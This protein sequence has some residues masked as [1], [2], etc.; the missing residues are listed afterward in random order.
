MSGGAVSCGGAEG[1][2]IGVV[3]GGNELVDGALAA[4]AA[5]GVGATIAIGFDGGSERGVVVLFV[6]ELELGNVECCEDSTGGVAGT[7]GGSEVA[8][9]GFGGSVFTMVEGAESWKNDGAGRASSGMSL[10]ESGG[11]CCGCDG[12]A[13]NVT[14]SRPCSPW[15]HTC[16]EAAWDR[17]EDWNEPESLVDEIDDDGDLTSGSVEKMMACSASLEDVDDGTLLEDVAGVGD[18][19]ERAAGVGV[20]AS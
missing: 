9:D 8:S 6:I 2:R 4:A 7:S 18:G 16:T 14:S 13:S 12:S 11:G 1:A 17:C 5:T 15:T 19:D 20:G 10:N 3:L